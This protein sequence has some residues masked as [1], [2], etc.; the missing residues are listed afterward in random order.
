MVQT[1]I[2]ATSVVDT[3]KYFSSWLYFLIPAALIIYSICIAVIA[4]V[5]WILKIKRIYYSLCTLLYIFMLK[6]IN[7]IGICPKDGLFDISNK[8]WSIIIFTLIFFV[9]SIIIDNWIISGYVFKE[10]GFLGT[11]FIREE[12]KTVVAEQEGYTYS[13][14]NGITAM[15]ET[16]TEIRKLFENEDIMSEI[17]SN[18]FDFIL[19]LSEVIEVYYKHRKLSVDINCETYVNSDIDSIVEDIVASNQ[20]SLYKKIKLKKVLNKKD[21]IYLENK[22]YNLMLVTEKSLVF[23]KTNDIILVKIRSIKEINLYDRYIIVDIVKYFEIYLLFIL[24]K[25]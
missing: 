15:F 18:K 14:E 13:L 16:I 3:R 8:A 4:D 6:H 9:S 19:R 11:K 2:I 12:S 10:L 20:L 24:S 25:L 5:K 23:N 1:Y 21:F 22:T 17:K 7:V